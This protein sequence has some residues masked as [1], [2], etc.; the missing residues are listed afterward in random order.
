MCELISRVQRS[1][2]PLIYFY[3]GAARLSRRL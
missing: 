3:S 1:T 2:K